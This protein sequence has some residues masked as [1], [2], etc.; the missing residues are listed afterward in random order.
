MTDIQNYNGYYIVWENE[1]PFTYNKIT[2]KQ[3]LT[4][5]LDVNLYDTEQEWLDVL[6]EYGIDPTYDPNRP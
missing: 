4:T 2:D 5:H 3:E 6:A 1:E